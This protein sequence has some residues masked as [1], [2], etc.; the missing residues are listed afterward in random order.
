MVNYSTHE[1]N[2]KEE[3]IWLVYPWERVGTYD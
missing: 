3:D 1:V 2:K